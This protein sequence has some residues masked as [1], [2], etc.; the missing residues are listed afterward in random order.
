MSGDDEQFCPVART[1]ELL[2]RRWMPLVLLELM[3]GRHRFNEIRLG[4][5]GSRPVS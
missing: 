2:T 3:G 4:W 5:P 1:A